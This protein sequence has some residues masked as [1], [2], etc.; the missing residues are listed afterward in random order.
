MSEKTQTKIKR[1][2]R[3][4]EAV[5]PE[6]RKKKQLIQRIIGVIAVILVIFMAIFAQGIN[7]KGAFIVLIGVGFGYVLQRSRFCLTAAI[8]DPFLTGGTELTKALI[9][10]LAVSSFLYMGINMAKFGLG[11]E[12]LNLKLAAGYIKPVGLHTAI[13]A[14]L[15]GIGAVIAGGCASGTLMR[16]G[17]GFTQQWIAIIFFVTG[18][19]IGKFLMPIVKKS[20]VLYTGKAIFLPS[21]F[22]G[23]LGAVIVHFGLLFALYIAA[24]KWSRRKQK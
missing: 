18:T 5:N 9:I 15:F 1:T 2:G 11:L 23:W 3:R 10:L 14:F 24:D 7:Q 12:T 19:I 8:R 20:S 6:Q 21:L 17:E 16:I 4:R 13:G 22:G